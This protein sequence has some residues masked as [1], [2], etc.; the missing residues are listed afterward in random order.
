MPLLQN[1]KFQAKKGTARVQFSQMKNRGMLPYRWNKATY[2][3]TSLPYK[4]T[5]TWKELTGLT[6]A[7]KIRKLINSFV[8]VTTQTTDLSSESPHITMIECLCDAG[9]FVVC[10]QIGS[11]LQNTFLFLLLISGA[12]LPCL[13]QPQFNTLWVPVQNSDLSS[14]QGYITQIR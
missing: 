9:S 1:S 11:Q 8:S 3:Q 5:L 2:L 13:P 14:C 12:D 10:L 6:T 7:K 4:N